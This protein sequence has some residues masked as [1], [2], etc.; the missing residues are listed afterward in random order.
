[1]Y[2]DTNGSGD[3]PYDE[4]DPTKPKPAGPDPNSPEELARINAIYG[5]GGSVYA[6]PTPTS[7]WNPTTEAYAAPKH[8]DAPPVEQ[9]GG[10]GGG[11]TPPPP[12]TPPP[13]PAPT[14]SAPIPP[15]N[16][17]G[18]STGPTSDP[19][20]D[21]LFNFLMQ[22]AHQSQIIDPNDP[23]IRNQADT[24]SA[25][26]T[27]QGR[28][29]LSELA[30]RKGAGGNIG[31]ES[32]MVSEKNAQ[33][34]A[35][36]EGELVQHE[37]DQRRQEIEN[38]LA[39]GAQFMTATQQMALQRELA[40][41]DNNMK[42]YQSQVQDQQF[43]RSLDVN[44]DQFGRTL[45]FQKS[46]GAANRGQSAGQFGATMSQREKEFNDNLR[47]RAYEYDTDNEFRRS[48]YAQR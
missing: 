7:P 43:G 15:P 14:G 34:G 36:H 2:S 31:A 19:R 24:Y 3:N 25:N 41:I 32:R 35:A 6:P 8:E 46:E 26:L 39:T 47:Q 1:M 40:T 10:G 29:Y 37:S 42:L 12:A 28:R 17:G 48:P 4:Q 45:D 11:G 44:K 21:D 38:A 5:P 27:R 22:R 18:G 9:P 23:M 13:T 16:T 30:E 20:G 33:A